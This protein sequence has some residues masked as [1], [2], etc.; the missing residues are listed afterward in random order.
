MQNIKITK[1]QNDITQLEHFN[2]LPESIQEQLLEDIKK[3]K[4]K[5][6]IAQKIMELSN[7]RKSK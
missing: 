4:L 2:R 6:T 3:K 5:E 7:K 1:Q